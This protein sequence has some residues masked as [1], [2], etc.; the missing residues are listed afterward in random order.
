MWKNKARRCAESQPKGSLLLVPWNHSLAGCSA[1][2]AEWSRCC[3]SAGLPQSWPQPSTLIVMRVYTWSTNENE[4]EAR[5]W[6]LQATNSITVTR[7]RHDALG[8]TWNAEPST[9]FQRISQHM[10]RIKKLDEVF[11]NIII[12][13][14]E[15]NIPSNLFIFSTNQEIMIS[16]TIKYLTNLR[17]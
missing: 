6:K 9:D 11:P 10:E 13:Q 7:A 8:K 16:I 17:D 4:F 14:Q 2:Y 12:L 15:K 5:L 3:K 1:N